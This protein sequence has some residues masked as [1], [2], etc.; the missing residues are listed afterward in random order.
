MKRFILLSFLFYSTQIV[1]TQENTLDLETVNTEIESAMNNNEVSKDTVVKQA[2]MPQEKVDPEETDDNLIGI[3]EDEEI[4]LNDTI[5]NQGNL[6]Q[7]K[8]KDEGVSDSILKTT[9]NEENVLNDS[10]TNK[11]EPV[12]EKLTLSGVITDRETGDRLVNV[13]VR[14]E[15]TSIETASDKNGSYTIK[16]EKG[17]HKIIYSLKNYETFKKDVTLKKKMNL[18]IKL[19]STI[20]TLSKMVIVEEKKNENITSTEMSVEKFEIE[21]IETVPVIMGEKDIMKTIQLTPGITTITEG[22]IGFVVRGSGI[23]ENMVLMDGMPLYYSSH[24]QGLYSVFNSDAVDNLTIYKGGTPASYG[25]RTSSVLDVRMKGDQVDEFHTKLSL[26]LITSKFSLEAP[27]IKDKLS[28]FGAGRFTKLSVGYIHD[29]IKNDDKGGGKDYYNKDGAKVAGNIGSTG[30]TNTTNSTGDGKVSGKSGSS[31]DFYFFNPSENWFDLNGKIVYNIN[32]K[33]SL[34]LSGFLGRDSAITAGGLTEWGNRAAA[35][36]WDHEYTP[37]LLSSTALTYSKYYTSA[38]GGIYKFYSGIKT[39]SFKHEF[40]LFPNKKNEIRFGLSSEYQKYNHGA[41]EDTEE[42]FGK[43][44][45]PM[46]ALENALYVGNDQKLSDKLSIY[47]GLRYSL[48][49]RMGPGNSYDYDEESNE[50]YDS[51]PFYA[52]NNIMHT[53]HNPEPRLSLTYILNE[54]NSMKFFYNRSAQYVRLMS[55]GMQLQWYDIWMP[56]TKNIEPLTVNQVAMGYFGNFADDQFQFSAETYYKWYK[57]AAAFE[58]GLHN[59]LVSNLEAFVA[60]GEGRSYGLEL[61]LKKPSGRLNGWLSYNLGR[62]E[63]QVDCINKGRWFASMFD[64]THDITA[65]L[66]FKLLENLSLSATFLYS[67]GNAITLPEAFYRIEGIPFPYWEGRNKYRLPSYHRLDFGVKYDLGILK[68]LLNKY[69]RN[70]KISLELS[71][72]NVYN[73]RNIVSMGYSEIGSGKGGNNNE[74]TSERSVFEPYGLSIYG[75][76]PSFLLN[77]EF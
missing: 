64:K 56:C 12:Q 77:I 52:R 14:K 66:C 19:K 49:F 3:D 34:N 8:I 46:Q 35:L 43:F 67:T 9:A 55:L 29:R 41:L 20:K 22:E 73:R 1:F 75:F 69:N 18:D 70:L 25:G 47:Y 23:D 33:N 48:Y 31:D 17:K 7:E 39:F 27:I 74:S 6:S 65:V 4:V 59:Y 44:M 57:N 51:I 76:M 68:N 32:D 38:A 5:S 16:L 58:D 54:K 53:Y 61:M 30:E 21:E 37:R 50:A 63:K 11:A 60:T 62:S 40:A 15:G 36:K 13:T 45:P 24:Q 26:G 71:G 28:I 72:Y 10:S 2:E 42:N